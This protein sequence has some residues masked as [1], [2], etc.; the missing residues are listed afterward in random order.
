MTEPETW[1]LP[2]YAK[3]DLRWRRNDL[4]AQIDREERLGRNTGLLHAARRAVK[5]L[6]DLDES[7]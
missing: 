4:Q 5:T 2:A 6:D 3:Q 1:T 7:R